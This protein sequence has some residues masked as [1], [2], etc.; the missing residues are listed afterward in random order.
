MTASAPASGMMLAGYDQV[1]N[2]HAVSARDEIDRE[3][4]LIVPAPA[5]DGDWGIADGRN[6]DRALSE[7]LSA[8]IP[9]V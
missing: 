7:R 4:R 1:F 3:Q 8:A 5:P 2:P 6:P 9:C